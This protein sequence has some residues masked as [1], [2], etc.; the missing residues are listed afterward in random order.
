M[1]NTPVTVT[2]TTYTIKLTGQIDD[3]RFYPAAAQMTTYTYD[4]LIGETSVT[5]PKGEITYYEYDAFQR[6]MNIK[7]KDGNINKHVDY[8]YKSNQ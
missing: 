1:V 3:V 4:P 8:H 7:D 5:D 2:G 6:L